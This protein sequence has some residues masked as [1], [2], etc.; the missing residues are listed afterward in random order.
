MHLAVL[1]AAALA[2]AVVAEASGAGQELRPVAAAAVNSTLLGPGEL[3]SLNALTKIDCGDA[4]AVAY[5]PEM[6]RPA[7]VVVYARG[8][9]WAA[10]AQECLERLRACLATAGAPSATIN[11]VIVALNETLPA[12]AWRTS[13]IRGEAL[14][15]TTT[16]SPSAA[17]ATRG[18]SRTPGTMPAATATATAL[19]TV[20]RTTAEAPKAPG[21]AGTP[22]ALTP[23]LEGGGAEGLGPGE[24]TLA[25]L[26]AATA[27]AAVAAAWARRRTLTP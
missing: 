24:K 18:E 1:A 17:A 10:A 3:G 23:R 8:P 5:G 6:G 26:A 21:G 4:L 20:Q 13:M 2:L 9:G 7:V 16:A 19:A 15:L 22:A 11:A 27:A 25:V 12:V 14:T